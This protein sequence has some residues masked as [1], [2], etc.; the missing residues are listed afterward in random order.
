MILPDSVKYRCVAIGD[1]CSELSSLE[2]T[3]VLNACEKR[4][5]EF[6]TGRHLLRGLLREFG[7]DYAQLPKAAGGGVVWPDG[8]CGSVAHT[9][10]FCAAVLAKTDDIA[11]VGID[12]EN[13][14]D[15]GERECRVFMPDDEYEIMTSLEP[16]IR[17]VRMAAAFSVRE[18]IYKC[19]NPVFGRWIDF[20]DARV[21]FSDDGTSLDV[22]VKNY[23]S[24]CGLRCR[25]EVK[26]NLVI[27]S[28]ML[29]EGKAGV[30]VRDYEER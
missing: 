24:L 22:T 16:K 6:S 9:D 5:N 17:Q 30:I 29:C 8:Y 7:I 25:Y 26:D 20:Q 23:E 12:I 13:I 18:A 10:Q 15:V 28:A 2:A 27:T 1:H 3:A 14:G 11:S 21:W 19:L 4:R